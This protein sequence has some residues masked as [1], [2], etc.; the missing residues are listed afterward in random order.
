MAGFEPIP[1]A[2]AKDGGVRH[3]PG[4]TIDDKGI[5]SFTKLPDCSTAPIGIK[6]Y[7]VSFTRD[8]GHQLT[9]VP[10]NIL[11]AAVGAATYGSRIFGQET[12]ERL[13]TTP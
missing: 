2:P 1:L 13:L 5:Q 10:Q 7:V 4:L 6:T 12:I 9:L 11:S 3:D 8:T